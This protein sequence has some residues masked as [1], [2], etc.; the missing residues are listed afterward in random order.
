MLI[1]K[2]VN[3]RGFNFYVSAD[4]RYLAKGGDKKGNGIRFLNMY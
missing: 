3:S 2:N 1:I 4:R